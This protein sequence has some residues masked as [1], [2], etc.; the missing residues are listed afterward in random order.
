MKKFLKNFVM[1]SIKFLFI[2]VALILT[3]SCAAQNTISFEQYSNYYVNDQDV[4][5]NVTEIRDS[6]GTLAAMQGDWSVVING[7]AYLFRFQL[8]TETNGGIIEDSLNLNYKIKDSN[9]NIIEDSLTTDLL[10]SQSFSYYIFNGTIRMYWIGAGDC[11][12]SGLLNLTPQNVSRNGTYTSMLAKYKELP[13]IIIE[14]LCPNGKE[15]NTFHDG[16]T[17]T[18]NRI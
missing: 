9:N 4:P 15:E 7:N 12:L 18:V 3:Y 8:A 14:N 17:F 6:N 2:T 11:K 10:D 16:Q 13:G 1:K 5:D